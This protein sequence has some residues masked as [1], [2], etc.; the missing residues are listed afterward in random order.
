MTNDIIDTR[1]DSNTNEQEL[2]LLDI[3]A[4]RQALGAEAEPTPATATLAASPST[5]MCPQWY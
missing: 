1:I 5:I 2:T 4:L 3:E